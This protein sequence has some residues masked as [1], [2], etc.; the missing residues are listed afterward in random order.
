MWV[1][2]SPDG[3][4]QKDCGVKSAYNVD[5]PNLQVKL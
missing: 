1:A 3:L 2:D 4:I 5:S